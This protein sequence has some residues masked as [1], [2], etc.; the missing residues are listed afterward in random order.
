MFKRQNMFHLDWPV[1]CVCLIMML[2]YYWSINIGFAYQMSWKGD[3]CNS[4]F[5]HTFILALINEHVDLCSRLSCGSASGAALFNIVARWVRVVPKANLTFWT[6]R[7]GIGTLLLHLR[8]LRNAVES[9][10]SE[11]HSHFGSERFLSSKANRSDERWDKM[12]SIGYFHCRK[13]SREIKLWK[14][15]PRHAHRPMPWATAFSVVNWT[16]AIRLL[17]QPCFTSFSFSLFFSAFSITDINL[18]FFFSNGKSEHIHFATT[19]SN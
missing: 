11:Y 1:A 19:T 18:I 5:I 14:I 3:A 2:N 6:I 4:D 16:S 13:S 15:S 17:D 7:S 8:S 10:E 12:T 9:D